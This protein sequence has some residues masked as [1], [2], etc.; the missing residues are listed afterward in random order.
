MELFTPQ[1]S[2]FFR[3]LVSKHREL[4]VACLKAFY[5]RLYSPD[6]NY[7]FH[8]S[9]V[10]LR[11]LFANMIR[12][13]TFQEADAAL[14]LESDED[15]LDTSDEYTLASSV[16]RL[17][18]KHGWL[19]EYLDKATMANAYRFSKPAKVVTKSFIELEQRTIHTKQR[20]VRNTR[21]ALF[22]F[23]EH[24]DPFDLADAH[25]Y[26][27]QIIEDLSDE[28]ADLDDRK[29][30]MLKS[31]AAGGTIA[32]FLDYMENHFKP[33]LAVKLAA[34][35]VER[36][37]RS[38]IDLVDR[39]RA[40]P[41]EQI[42]ACDKKLRPMI[43]ANMD[44]ARG[45][46][47]TLGLAERVQQ[48]I[49]TAYHSKLSELRASLSSFSRAA[50]QLIRQQVSMRQGL[51]EQLISRVVHRL[52]AMDEAEQNQALEQLG[53]SINLTHVGL[54]DPASFSLRKQHE[55]PELSTAS[56]VQRQ[57]TADE[58]VQI[59]MAQ[60]ESTAFTISPLM[61]R[62]FLLAMVGE[63]GVKLS[64]L[65]P[66]DPPAILTIMHAIEA[67]SS[68]LQGK[69]ESLEVVPLNQ[70]FDTPYMTADDFLIRKLS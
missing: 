8:V 26:S 17:L 34:D 59:A 48:A 15:A 54:V 28:I 45:E 10:E 62:D 21:N 33:E 36:H 40:W 60:A 24:G 68:S 18:M 39:I 67:A 1:R 4:I 44:L 25:A 49:D 16:M 69:G 46:S 7:G 52:G 13:F 55:R 51:G 58:R 57:P 29:S 22:A 5:D 63:N 65:K 19:E 43:P 41:A 23:F 37:R 6:N 2:Q 53:N 50:T 66:D 42:E 64:A 12:D 47:P 70:T 9:R 20:N 27:L 56:S 35:S 38:I 32:E 11:E 30:R 31:A 3:P 61:I 14:E